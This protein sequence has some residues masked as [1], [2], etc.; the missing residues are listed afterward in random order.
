MGDMTNDDRVDLARDACEDFAESTGQSV[1][2][3]LHNIITD[4]MADLLHLANR[5]GLCADSLLRR[6]NMHYEAEISE[7]EECDAVD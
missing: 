2:D 1:E 6:A 7:E 5:N 3:E 4:L